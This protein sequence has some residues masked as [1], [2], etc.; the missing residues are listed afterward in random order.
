MN[1]ALE[2]NLPVDEFLKYASLPENVAKRL[3]ELLEKLQEQEKEIKYLER[4]NELAWEQVSFAEDLIE[5]I[6]T[7]VD[8]LPFKKTGVI[9]EFQ[10]AYKI[11][12]ENSYFE[13]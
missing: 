3:D 11:I 9:P 10:K 8:N 6:D 2:N 7:L 13:R 4:R 5:Q 12:C 1:K